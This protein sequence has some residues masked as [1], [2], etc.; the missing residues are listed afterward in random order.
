MQCVSR[1]C[2][3]ILQCEYLLSKYL[4]ETSTQLWSVVL[5]NQHLAPALL[6]WHS[7]LEY[8][9]YQGQEEWAYN[10]RVCPPKAFMKTL[11]PRKRDCML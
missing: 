5:C 9:C 1:Y 10:D 2:P 8:A 7:Q 3:D 11:A 6:S 4:A